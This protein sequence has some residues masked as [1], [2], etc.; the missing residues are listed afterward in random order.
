[1]FAST[2]RGSSPYT[3]STHGGVAA[4]VTNQTASRQQLQT[5]LANPRGEN[6]Y[7]TG[8]VAAVTNQQARRW[9]LQ[10]KRRV[11]GSYKPPGIA[12]A[13]TNY[14]YCCSGTSGSAAVVAVRVIEPSRPRPSTTLH[15]KKKTNL[16]S[17]YDDPK[18][19]ILS[20][21]AAWIRPYHP[22]HS[23]W[24]SLTSIDRPLPPSMS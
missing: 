13:V 7:L 16:I 1:M 24:C 5:A 15:S 3:A 20:C 2:L 14:Q 10:T 18:R 12:V 19:N 6:Y 17:G 8:L 23:S 21:Y 4:S 11:G 9:Q 22:R